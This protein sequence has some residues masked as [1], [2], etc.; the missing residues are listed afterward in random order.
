MV[1]EEPCA[2]PPEEPQ[3]SRE[4]LKI[5]AESVVDTNLSHQA[6][7]DLEIWALYSFGYDHTSF[8]FHVHFLLS[9]KL[10]YICPLL[11]FSYQTVNNFIYNTVINVYF[12]ASLP[13]GEIELACL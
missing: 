7:L 2:N 6:I 4:S 13:R 1:E 9:L 5:K 8:I 3:D 12:F 10:M 11:W